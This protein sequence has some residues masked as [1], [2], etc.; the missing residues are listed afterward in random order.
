MV[1]NK[2]SKPRYKI[3]M[4]LN[5][6]IIAGVFGAMLLGGS[7]KFSGCDNVDYVSSQF[8]NSH[9]VELTD[10]E[11]SGLPSEVTRA[12]KV[13]YSPNKPRIELK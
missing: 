2:V 5:K 12:Y 1:T 4:D 3:K 6:K 11:K 9:Y 10:R 7:L 13:E 8:P